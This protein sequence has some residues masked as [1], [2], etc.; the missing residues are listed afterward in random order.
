MS[1]IDQSVFHYVD[2]SIKQCKELAAFIKKRTAAEADHAKALLKITNA[3]QRGGKGVAGI[4]MALLQS[5]RSEAAKAILAKS[6]LWHS[7]TRMLADTEMI[8]NAQLQKTKCINQDILLPFVGY[9]KEMEVTR[10]LHIERIQDYTRNVEDACNCLKKAQKELEGTLTQTSDLSSSFNRAQSNQSAK[11]RDL[12]RLSQKLQTSVDKTVRAQETVKMYKELCSQA[13]SEYFQ[14]L[15]PKL[16]EDVLVK[17]EERSVAVSRVMSDYLYIESMHQKSIT[18]SIHDMTD[19]LLSVELSSDSKE[20]VDKLIRKEVV[21]RHQIHAKQHE[22]PIHTGCILVKRGNIVNDWIPQFCVL[23]SDKFL[24]MYDVTQLERPHSSVNMKEASIIDI[25]TSMFGKE[26]CLQLS[27]YTLLTGRELVNM[28]FETEADKSEWSHLLN[29]YCYCCS[30]CANRNGYNA[31]LE[32][33]T[34][35]ADKDNVYRLVRSV[36][37]T[38]MESKELDIGDLD[39]KTLNAFCTIQLGDLKVAKTRSKE[40]DAPFWGEEFFFDSIRPHFRSLKVLLSHNNRLKRHLDVG[41]VEIPFDSLKSNKRTEEWFQ[42][43]AKQ[44]DTVIKGSIRLAIKYQVDHVLP[45]KEYN[46][47]L[48]LLTEPKFRALNMLG[49]V[50]PSAMRA[51]LGKIGVRILLAKGLEVDG[52]SSLIESDVSATSDPNIIFR[53]NTLA[54]KTMD[55]FMSVVGMEY[56]HASIGKEIKAIY[57]STESCEV[58]PLRV[59]N[60]EAA[61]RNFT[62]LMDHVTSIW[63]SILASVENCPRSMVEI[64]S[65][66]HD[67]ILERWGDVGVVKY[68]AVSGF[69]FLRFFCPAIL[70]PNLFKIVDDIPEGNRARTFTLI[71]KILQNLANLAEFGQKEQYLADCNEFIKEQIPNMKNLIDKISSRYTSISATPA[72]DFSARIDVGRETEALF[73]YFVQLTKDFENLRDSKSTSPSDVYVAERL[74]SEF[75][76]LNTLHDQFSSASPGRDS[77]ALTARNANSVAGNMIR[78]HSPS[79]NSATVS[80]HPVRFGNDFDEQNGSSYTASPGHSVVERPEFS[81]NSPGTACRPL[82]SKASES[83]I[84]G[85]AASRGSNQHLRSAYDV[86]SM[87]NGSIV[88]TGEDESG[89]SLATFGS[90]LSVNRAMSSHTGEGGDVVGMSGIFGNSRRPSNSIWASLKG[91]SASGSSLGVLTAPVE[92]NYASATSPAAAVPKGKGPMRNLMNLFSQRRGSKDAG[93]SDEPE[94]ATDEALRY[95]EEKGLNAWNQGSFFTTESDNWDE[96]RS[97]K[98]VETNPNDLQS[99]HSLSMNVHDSRASSISSLQSNPEAKDDRQKGAFGKLTKRLS[100]SLTGNLG[101]TGEKETSFQDPNAPPVPILLQ[102]K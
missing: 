95:I 66:I 70:S 53:G 41:F 90:S 17:E 43:K 27:Q 59:D 56:L 73:Q 48:V 91:H 94:V 93:N 99:T 85:F 68:S 98:S 102:K 34:N 38:V 87:S 65:S 82:D 37:L 40:G 47:L 30:K 63:Q 58:D 78:K 13:Q 89:I 80:S 61:K 24:D 39:I 49:S 76:R 28:S 52:I 96:S 69:I 26:H 3:F 54:T 19:R 21:H 25:H 50:A 77:T 83:S 29:M 18:D 5:E 51:S 60:P 15:L 74:L 22:N 75:K 20:I 31:E 46:P 23:T 2:E 12:E 55:T 44:D 45:R 16:C 97:A 42:I 84:A 32:C 14:I 7:F 101:G 71:A 62:R 10:K 35:I 88:R 8:A 11:E 64:M 79:V 36:E 100:M 72:K 9:I 1:G 81:V 57:E 86:G 92:E 67:C 4:N 6:S 33:N